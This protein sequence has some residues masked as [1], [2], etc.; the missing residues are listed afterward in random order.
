ML[1]RLSFSFVLSMLISSAIEAR[2]FPGYYV[3][4]KGDSVHCN[5]QFKDWEVTPD[6]VTVHRGSTAST[7][8]PADISG[9]GIYG[10]GDYKSYAISYH[11]GNYSSLDAPDTFSDSIT[12]KPSFLKVLLTGK[13]S[14]YE[15]TE[16]SH[17]YY[18]YSV[19]GGDITELKYRVKRVGMNLERDET[20]KKTIFTLFASEAISYQ[21]SNKITKSV[22]SSRDIVPLFR[23]LNEKFS[24]E[25]S[26]QKKR[27]PTQFDLFIGGL[28]HQ[29]P[30]TVEGMYSEPSNKLDG[31]QSITGGLNFQ[32]FILSNFRSM[33]V[34]ASLAFD[35]YNAEANN[36]D[37]TKYYGSINNYR[38]TGYTENFSLNNSVLMLDIYTQY[39]FNPLNKVNVYA[40]AG[41]VTNFVVGGTQNVVINYNSS[42]TGV[43]RGV[44]VSYTDQGVKEIELRKTYYNVHGGLGL[45]AGRHK[46]EY[47]YYTP[48]IFDRVYA[49]K[50][51]MMGVHYYY[52]IIKKR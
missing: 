18:F 16:S 35:K 17:A 10:Y 34:G 20:Y 38:N 3:T 49:F 15:L 47:T 29:F 5:F 13:Y 4:L 46:I 1:T 41:I 2:D 26:V 43:S 7:L 45:I 48:G 22:Y 42:T 52:T 30:T 33:A 25:K 6:F 14:L 39:I 31:S 51:K 37:S 23:V 21:Y 9:F 12:S 8:Y 11:K 36:S 40:K 27:R 50:M 24:G 19:S 32:Y 44:P 28:N